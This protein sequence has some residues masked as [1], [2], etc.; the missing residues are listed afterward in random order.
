MRGDGNRQ[1]K[2]KNYWILFAILLLSLTSLSPTSDFTQTNSQNNNTNTTSLLSVD[3]PNQDQSD[4]ILKISVQLS[5]NEFNKLELLNK[6]FIQETGIQVELSNNPSKSEYDEA[7]ISK[8]LAMGEGS[9]VLLME[10]D[11]IR[12]LAT[13]GYLLP[14]ESYL[15]SSPGGSVLRSLL[16]LVEWNGYQWGTPFDMNPYVLVWQPKALV[17]M[18]IT[19]PP[20]TD[21]TWNN[22]LSKQLQRKEKTLLA[23]DSD[24]SYSLAALIGGMGGNILHPEDHYLKWIEQSLPHMQL[25]NSNNKHE[26]LQLVHKGEIPLY[27]TE[28]SATTSLRKEG[29]SVAIPG[30]FYSESPSFLRSRSFGV[31]SQSLLPEQSSEWI[32]Y[33][34]SYDIQQEWLYATY[35]LPSLSAIYE[36]YTNESLDTQIKLDLLNKLNNGDVV[37]EQLTNK[38]RTDLSMRVNQLLTGQLTVNQFKEEIKSLGIEIDKLDEGK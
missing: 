19:D 13:K 10:S 28:Y 25:V 14:V 37:Y 21:G 7:S 6:R 2:R 5:T 20:S 3:S 12:G 23:I 1:M 31:S 16:P 17:E 9:D 27:L 34:T 22:L 36:N 11:W 38:A 33:M 32:A 29:L 4:Q 15:K 30:Y 26:V 35:R 24:E 18:G 8:F